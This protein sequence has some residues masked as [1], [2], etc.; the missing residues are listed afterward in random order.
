MYNAGVNRKLRIIYLEDEESD[1]E[2]VKR[3]LTKGGFEFILSWV[4]NKTEFSSAIAEFA[5]DIVLSDH[6]LAAFDSTRAYDMLKEAGLDI[7]FIL[8]TANISE[9]F[10]VRMMK[11]GIA[12]YLL[13]DRL[14]RLPNAVRNA[15]EK[16]YTKKKEREYHEQIIRA[17]EKLI[18]HIQNTPLGFIEWDD[19]LHI[20]SWSNR[21]E[22]IFGWTLDD[23]SDLEKTGQRFVYEQDHKLLDQMLRQLLAGL[24]PVSN[25]QYRSYT[26]YGDIIWCEWFNSA[27]KNNDDEVLTIMSLVQDIT[28]RKNAEELLRKSKANVTAIIEN[29]GDC[30]Y[31][32]DRDFRYITFN[33]SLKKTMANTHGTVLHAGDKV[34]DFGTSEGKNKNEWDLRYNEV[35]DGKSLHFVKDYSTS[36]RRSYLSFSINPIYE[37]TV[38]F[39]LSCFVRDMT[40]QVVSE[41]KLL[42]SEKRFR[43]M[44]E[45]NTDAIILH[46]E[47][48]VVQYSSPMA[49]KMLGI[50]D[51]NFDHEFL[52]MIHTDDYNMALHIKAESRQHPGKIIPFMF[53]KKHRNGNF[54]WIE[55]VMTNMLH[56]ENVQGIITNFRDISERKNAE[57][58]KSKMVTQLVEQNNDLHQFSFIA[59]HN[60]R[61]PV[62]RILGLLNLLNSEDMS[63][64]VSSILSMLKRSTVNIDNVIK[65]LS[66]ILNM[67][68]EEHLL[69]DV[70]FAS[71]LENIREI[72]HNQ[73]EICSPTFI[74][75]SGTSDTFHTIKSYFHSIL[76]NLISNA[77]RFRSPKRPLV[78][79]IG[80]F[81]SDNVMGI[82]VRDNGLGIDLKSFR[83]NMF[84]LY[85]RF[86][87]D[88]EGTG[89]GLYIVKTQVQKLHGTIAIE[90]VPDSG[91]LFT[92]SFPILTSEVS[93]LEA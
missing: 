12:D 64:Q 25:F 67:R 85:Q 16:W 19:Q 35:L 7:P 34:V 2:L 48:F 31:S 69:E 53:R 79:E 39:G 60:L 49:N 27:I 46:D 30:V 90:S 86:H 58:E 28:E 87:L 37:G 5:P 32:I 38:I 44:I 47:N 14:Q 3:E 33:T 65:D 26:K 61:G 78:V 70:S 36:S 92:I 29:T 17:H 89:I 41:E 6:S 56:D 42:K 93:L 23:L 59:S 43:A 1:M 45:N 8:I 88:I 66:I 74:I 83:Q 24:T 73:I 80:S 22:E 77:I 72:L 15:M 51:D 62:A 20:T 50:V 9:E 63:E 13:K 68:H 40:E 84:M 54:I 76:Y 91:S 82:F 55:G 81:Q 75:E 10:A 4:T 11:E 21:A 18:F 52:E 57:D 71:T